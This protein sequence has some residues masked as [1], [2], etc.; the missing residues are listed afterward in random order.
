VTDETST[1]AGM[2][3]PDPGAGLRVG[4]PAPDV[5]L[6]GEGDRPL[7]LSELWSRQPLVLVFL[8]HFG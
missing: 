8:R 6:L 2:R 4:S 7:R 5:T 1:P 3:P